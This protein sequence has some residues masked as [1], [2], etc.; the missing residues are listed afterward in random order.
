[1][2]TKASVYQILKL[3]LLLCQDQPEV[4]T[5]IGWISISLSNIIIFIIIIINTDDIVCMGK[6]ESVLHLK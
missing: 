6:K 2:D 4:H 5:Y 3:L 1:M